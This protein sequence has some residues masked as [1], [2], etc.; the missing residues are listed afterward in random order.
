M[1]AVGRPA[2]AA[3][4]APLPAAPRGF[5]AELVLWVPSDLD[6]VGEAV[7]VVTRHIE[8]HF[9]HPR[10]IRF[11][12][13][14]ALGEAL[15]NAILYGNRSDPAKQVAVR[16]RFGRT[17]VEMEVND[18][19]EG[20]DP[21]MVPDPTAP[22]RIDAPGGRGIFLIRKLVD[23]VRFNERGNTICMTLRRV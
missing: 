17:I 4:V 21:A 22:E 5:E 9:A 7:D 18:D 11:N 12:L 3:R 13:R 10:A 15:A 14:V 6:R 8:V 16:A 2:L 23:E 1:S 20:F 19:G